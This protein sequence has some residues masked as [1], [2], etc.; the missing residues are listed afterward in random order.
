M[1]IKISTKWAW[2]IN[3]EADIMEVPDMSSME[4][5]KEFLED[6]YAYSDNFSWSDKFRGYDV[7][8]LDH[9]PLAILERELKTCEQLIL[10][11]QERVERLR[12]QIIEHPDNKGK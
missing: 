4:E 3:D 5:L 8:I 7:K 10:A 6:T 2:G 9:P 11:R 1:W 12:K